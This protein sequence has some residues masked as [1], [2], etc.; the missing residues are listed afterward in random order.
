MRAGFSIT[1]V[2]KAVF[3]FSSSRSKNKEPHS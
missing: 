3:R 2:L 1:K